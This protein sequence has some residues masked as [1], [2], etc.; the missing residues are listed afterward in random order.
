MPTEVMWGAVATLAVAAIGAVCGLAFRNPKVYAR[1][2]PLLAVLCG[3]SAFS[4]MIYGLG[5][6]EGIAWVGQKLFDGEKINEIKSPFTMQPV[7]II[8]AIFGVLCLLLAL[9]AYL[10]LS[11]DKTEK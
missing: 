7:F 4:Y 1:L 9:P 5:F 2:F 11:D 6:T 8:G 10:G 3:I